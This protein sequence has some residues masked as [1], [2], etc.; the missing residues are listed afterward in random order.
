MKNPGPASHRA[1]RVQAKATAPKRFEYDYRD[2]ME[3]RSF[4][5]RNLSECP[6]FQIATCK[7]ALAAA[8]RLPRPTL[9]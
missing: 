4:N 7:D 1:I 3:D 8:R 9:P 2:M 5:L 6:E